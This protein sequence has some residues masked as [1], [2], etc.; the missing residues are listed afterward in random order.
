MSIPDAWRNR[1]TDGVTCP[2]YR[3]L[4]KC[5]DCSKLVTSFNAIRCSKCALD[6]HNTRARKAALAAQSAKMERKISERSS[7]IAEVLGCD[8]SEN[9]RR[10]AS[11][12]TFTKGKDE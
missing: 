3:K 8:V 10:L 2:K 1:N 7:R 9:V 12:V 4:P 5:R 11:M 6:H